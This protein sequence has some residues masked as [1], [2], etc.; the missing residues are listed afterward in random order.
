M[1]I[2]CYSWPTIKTFIFGYIGNKFVPI[3]ESE[4]L[5]LTHC[6]EK[7]L[8]W[9]KNPKLI[10]IFSN[11]VKMLTSVFVQKLPKVTTVCCR[12]VVKNGIKFKPQI[13]LHCTALNSLNM[14]MVNLSSLLQL[15]WSFL[16]VNTQKVCCCFLKFVS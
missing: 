13:L 5:W 3:L 12:Q 9:K 7:L 6:K 1:V 16:H 15:I 8:P 4:I 2:V 11:W 14:Q 10:N